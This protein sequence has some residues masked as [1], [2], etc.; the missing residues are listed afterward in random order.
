MSGANSTELPLAAL[1]T[2]SPLTDADFAAVRARVRS[3]I[4]QTEKRRRLLWP[5]R[6]A[7]AVATVVLIGLGALRIIQRS[8]HSEPYS[9]PVVVVRKPFTIPAPLPQVTQ[10]APKPMR[11][12]AR[13]A[14]S[15]PRQRQ[16]PE[17]RIQI[18]TADPDIRIIWI[19]NA[20]ST[21]LKEE[22]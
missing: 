18:Q 1:R 20:R 5:L 8:N 7:M 2:P 13:R 11:T 10:P 15:V 9:A 14:H 19:V 21:F 16:Q 12:V 3:Q 17:M 4:A 6:F 22:S